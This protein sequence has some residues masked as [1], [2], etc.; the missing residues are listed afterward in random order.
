[1]KRLVLATAVAS[2]TV[3]LFGAVTAPAAAHAVTRSHAARDCIPGAPTPPVGQSPKCLW[4]GGNTG[5]GFQD[6]DACQ[7]AANRYNSQDSSHKYQCEDVF[8]NGRHWVVRY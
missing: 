6:S 3:G 7:T 1:M 5:D 2:L 8:G 4:D